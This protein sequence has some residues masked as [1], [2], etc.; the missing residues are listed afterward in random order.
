MVSVFRY[1]YNVPILTVLDRSN[2][3]S[4][5]VFD[6]YVSFFEV[7]RSFRL[8][9]LL[10]FLLLPLLPYLR[11]PRFLDRLSKVIDLVLS[12]L[13]QVFCTYLILYFLDLLLHT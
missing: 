9:L 12:L 3:F 10:L 11:L 8:L 13:L 7:I 6:V 2:L 5:S 1:G 4:F